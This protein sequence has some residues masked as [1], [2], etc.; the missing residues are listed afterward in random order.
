MHCAL[1]NYTGNTN[2]TTMQTYTT[3][4]GTTY[5]AR[6]L[7]EQA[8]D[9]LNAFETRR[10]ADFNDANTCGN[11]LGAIQADHHARTLHELADALDV[12]GHDL[13]Y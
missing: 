12:L 11:I 10:R 1:Y 2:T 9:A 4:N 3:K 5:D 8:R 6:D 13:I 7:L